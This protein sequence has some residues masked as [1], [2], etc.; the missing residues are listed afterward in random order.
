MGGGTGAGGFEAGQEVADFSQEVLL[1][2]DMRS[3]L[4]SGDV[5]ALGQ[6]TRLSM[7]G[8]VVVSAPLTINGD[9]LDSEKMSIGMMSETAI[10]RSTG[11]W[12]T[13][14]VPH[15]N[16]ELY[17]E[18]GVWMET[19]CLDLAIHETGLQGAKEA[20]RYEKY[21]FG[22]FIDL[23]QSVTFDI[24]RELASGSVDKILQTL[25]PERLK[26]SAGV[27]LNFSNVLAYYL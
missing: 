24:R 2:P 12:F 7:P 13:M 10:L 25:A 8:L 15:D 27:L 20:V 23:E 9:V 11:E 19:L 6:V 21:A 1:V 14:T 5:L 3:R 17:E 26:R 4:A 16:S 22:R 18:D